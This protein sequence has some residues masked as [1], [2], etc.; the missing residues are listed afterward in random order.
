[1]LLDGISAREKT[2]ITNDGKS[3]TFGVE[4]VRSRLKK[5]TA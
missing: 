5:I 3:P 2:R 4:A 1:M